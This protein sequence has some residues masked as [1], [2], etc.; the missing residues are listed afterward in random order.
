M[1]NVAC[2]ASV[3][4]GSVYYRSH[5]IASLAWLDEAIQ[6]LAA[7]GIHALLTVTV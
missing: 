5:V 3:L 6:I 7:H 1:G 2:T 4:L